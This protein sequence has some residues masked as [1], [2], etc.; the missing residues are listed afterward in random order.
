MGDARLVA[1]RVRVIR[2]SE[3]GSEPLEIQ[4]DNR[5]LVRWE[6]TRIRH[7]WPTFQ[8][9]PF[10]WLTFLAWSAATRA[11]VVSDLTYERWEADVL[12]VADTRDEDENDEIGR[13]TEAGPAPA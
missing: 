1:P 8:E 4:T 10:K 9:A 3:N 7:K 13:P 11:G 2:A 6:Q 12:S 5:D